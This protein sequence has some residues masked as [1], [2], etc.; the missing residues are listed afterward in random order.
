V[1]CAAASTEKALPQCF[2]SATNGVE[3]RKL[4]ACAYFAGS[5]LTLNTASRG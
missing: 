5:P 4:A 1:F 3:L 2:G